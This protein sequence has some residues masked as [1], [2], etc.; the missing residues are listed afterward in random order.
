MRRR[1]QPAEVADDIARA[2]E[3]KR[4]FEREAEWQLNNKKRRQLASTIPA[5]T[6]FRDLGVLAHAGP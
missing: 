2:L 1:G 3:A 6:T 4:R 5:G